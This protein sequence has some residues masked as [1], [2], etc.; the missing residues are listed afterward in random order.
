M[1]ADNKPPGSAFGRW[2]RRSLTLRLGQLADGFK[3]ESSDHLTA[4]PRTA[5]EASKTGSLRT[6]AGLIT[7]RAFKAGLLSD[8]PGLEALV[9][10]AERGPQ[11][12]PGAPKD[13]SGGLH[14]RDG[15]VVNEHLAADLFTQ[16]VVGQYAEI[17]LPASHLEKVEK[18]R[19][20]GKLGMVVDRLRPGAIKV[21]SNSRG[22]L[23]PRLRPEAFRETDHMRRAL[24][25]GADAFESFQLWCARDAEMCELACRL[26]ADMVVQPDDATTPRNSDDRTK[27]QVAA[28]VRNLGGEFLSAREIAAHLHLKD[29]Q[30]LGRLLNRWRTSN[31]SSRGTDWK[32]RTDRGPREA[33]FLFRVEAVRELLIEHLQRVSAVADR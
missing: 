27:E 1:S 12:R 11:G 16:L 22:G 31:G 5:G 3:A 7:W 30:A 18:L 21:G 4:R 9:L 14:E 33:K 28:L 6:E 8:L 29:G 2:S 32:E 26:L 20:T 25:G 15:H 19:A 24:Q 13:G 23:L 17:E 10:R